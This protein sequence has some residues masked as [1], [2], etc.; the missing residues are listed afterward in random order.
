MND[1]PELQS[2][3]CPYQGLEPYTEA[4]Q[5]YFVGREADARWIA[6]NLLGGP[7]SV[8]YGVSGVGK[9][10]VLLAGVLPRLRKNPGLA[11]TVFRHWQGDQF[12]KQLKKAIAE[13]VIPNAR[14]QARRDE[15]LPFDEFLRQCNEALD[16]P[17]FLIFDQW[18]EYFLY[19]PTENSFDLELARA[20][21]RRDVSAHFLF[22]MREE[23]LSKLD[24]FRTSIPKVMGNMLR[25]KHLDPAAAEAAIRRPLDVY[26]S[27]VPADR[28]V[29]IE[30]KLV[31][32]LIEKSARRDEH[33]QR[34]TQSNGQAREERQIATP[35]LQLLLT[36]LWEE[37]RRQ[38]SSALRA[39]TLDRLGG[40]QNVVDD[41]FEK[42]IEQ[43]PAD[44]RQLAGRT[45]GYLVTPA[46]GKFAQTPATLARWAKENDEAPV[47]QL[48]EG[49]AMSSN[50]RILRKVIVTGRPDQYEIFHDVLGPSILKWQ[51]KFEQEQA[52]KLAREQAAKEAKERER[53]LEQ[54]KLLAAEQQKRLKQ[55]RY[56]MFLFSLLS[57]GM[58]AASVY[59]SKQQ[60]EAEKAKAEALSLKQAADNRSKEAEHERDRANI[61]KDDANK[62]RAET[63]LALKSAQLAQAQALEQRDL[64]NAAKDEAIKQQEI[65]LSRELAANSAAQLKIDPGLSLRFAVEAMRKPTTQAEDSLRSNFLETQLDSL[66]A[67]HS[68]VVSSATFSPDG[69]FVVTASRDNTAGVRNAADG[70]PVAQLAGH[71]G[72]VN[73]AAFSPDG[74]FVVTASE[75]HTARVWNAAD[76]QPVAQ[77]TGHIS[78]VYSAAFSPDGKFVVTASRDKTARVWNA[79]AGQPVAQLKGNTG[80]VNRAAFSA[81]GQFVVTTS[82]DK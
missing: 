78:S 44:Q 36:R 79:A 55:L 26:N 7:L 59:A 63:V 71:T 19:H 49:L 18:E 77:L 23:E 48:L 37:E 66:L 12:E 34:L 51:Q 10:S 3:F 40:A 70:Q 21:G 46:G 69:R 9:S 73:S 22:A 81:D 50:V 33:E 28:Q 30:D 38:D 31:N 56:G 35:V 20:I 27:R 11:V 32:S 58:L 25:L 43:L 29:S 47:R 45:F 24:R 13:A 2:D 6:S 39:A 61:A 82:A 64:A 42:V 52:E 54:T 62:A 65:A 80:R 72:S 14:Q 67:G 15:S 68:D 4:D 16:G 76:G 74:K 5:D 8:L 75:D 60:K 53:E 57:L 41:Y 1:I 17:V